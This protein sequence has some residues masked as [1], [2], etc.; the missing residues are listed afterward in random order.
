MYWWPDQE[1][2]EA[3]SSKYKKHSPLGKQKTFKSLKAGQDQTEDS[4]KLL[5]LNFLSN[6]IIAYYLLGSGS[7]ALLPGI[8]RGGS[9]RVEP[10]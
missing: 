2:G 8:R 9:T 4:G 5:D 3:A 10:G 7:Q 1:T 6:D